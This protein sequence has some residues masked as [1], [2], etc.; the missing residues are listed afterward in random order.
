MLHVI[1]VQDGHTLVVERG[2]RQ[3]SIR[4]AGVEIVDEAGAREL[5]RW[6]AGSA[7]IMAE[8][9]GDGW[10]VWRTPDALDLNAELV[11]RGFARAIR[12]GIAP[13]PQA[14]VTYLGEINLPPREKVN[15][16]SPPQ[17]GSGTSRRSSA[18]QTRPPQAGRRSARPAS[19]NR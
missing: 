12:P 14:M 15:A 5:L 8:P 19:K 13:R 16:P 10:H 17:S 7:W 18:K 4:L 11:L 3:E 6:T 2:G 9:A 1:S